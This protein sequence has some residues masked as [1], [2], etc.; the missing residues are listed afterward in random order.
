MDASLGAGAVSIRPSTASSGLNRARAI[1]ISAKLWISLTAWNDKFS[2]EGEF[3]SFE[4]VEVLPKPRRDPM[5]G[6]R[7]VDALDWAGQEGF[8]IMMDPHAT[9]E[10]WPENSYYRDK[11]DERSSN[12]RT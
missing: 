5:P 10:S 3:W 8:S 6:G 1:P 9:F 7:V 12:Q 11:L 2:Y 4:D